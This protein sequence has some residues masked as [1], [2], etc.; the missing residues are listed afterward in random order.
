LSSP[1]GREPQV[2]RS[3]KFKTAVFILPIRS[4][5]SVVP[6]LIE[7]TFHA[8]KRGSILLNPGPLSL[9]FY[10][11]IPADSFEVRDRGVYAE[12]VRQVLLS[13]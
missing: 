8:L 6:V 9:T 5:I 7:G 4:R 1:K 2:E 11:P 3:K 10:D 12:K 13:L